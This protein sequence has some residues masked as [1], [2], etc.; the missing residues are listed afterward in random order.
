[1][2]VDA[3]VAVSQ[4]DM[5][6]QLRELRKLVERLYADRRME[7]G[8]IGAGGLRFHSGG[9]A[10]FVDGGDVQIN[11]GGDL[12]IND[13]GNVT[14][15]DGGAVRAHYEDDSIAVMWGRL[16]IQ[17]GGEHDGH[18]LLVQDNESGN[19]LDIFRAKRGPDGNTV[20]WVGEIN[21]SIPDDVEPVDEVALEARLTRIRNYGADNL[22]LQCYDGDA[23][24]ATVDS[25]LVSIF[26]EDNDVF[27][28]YAD[29]TDPANCVLAANGLIQR[30]T[31]SRRYKDDIRDADIDPEA[32]L[33]LRPRT[34]RPKATG[35]GGGLRPGESRDTV[36]RTE[37]NP[38]R[39]NHDERRG[40]GFIAEEL[41]EIGLR[42]FVEHDEDGQARSIHYD[43]LTTAL[44]AVVQRQQSQI[45]DLAQRVAALES[46]GSPGRAVA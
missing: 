33:R 13:G 18:G 28:T 27:V 45:A 38:S 34:W 8:S 43:R 7:S 30:S 22:V 11:D 4:G 21:G 16:V 36:R 10:R 2:G 19:N 3:E 29:T 23:F 5:M 15:N 26:S 9:S 14:V 12:I 25:G 6:R 41:D 31:S 42:Q 40:I 46:G 37:P 35:G 39:P 17:E 24:F 32:V 1:M 44:V 20:V